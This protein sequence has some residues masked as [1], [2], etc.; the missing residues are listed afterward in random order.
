MK[1]LVSR[2]FRN[3]FLNPLDILNSYGYNNY[4][5]VLNSKSF[6]IPQN[7]ERVFIVSVRK[8]IDKGYS[9]TEPTKLTKKVRDFLD[10]EVERKYYW[11]ENML[12][13]LL[14]RKEQGYSQFVQDSYAKCFTASKSYLETNLVRIKDGTKKGYK[15]FIPTPETV[16]NLSFP[17]SQTKRGRVKNGYT[18]T[19]DTSC[20]VGVFENNEIR[21]LT[22][23]ECWR[24]L[25]FEDNDYWAAQYALEQSFYN[26]RDRSDS[27]MYKMAGNS[28]VVNVLENVLRNLLVSSNDNSLIEAA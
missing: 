26:G 6:N 9:F 3:D 4:W 10:N 5:C 1:N 27:Q 18:P 7:R 12:K 2:R 21:R 15:E 11:S 19:L 22:P 25:G 13:L 16:L 28:I 8:D 17:N 23:L 14:R 20:N 24:L